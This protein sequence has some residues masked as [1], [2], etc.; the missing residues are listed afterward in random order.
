MTVGY[1][2]VG[3]NY[4]L[5][6]VRGTPLLIVMTFSVEQSAQTHVSAIYTDSPSRTLVQSLDPVKS[7]GN[8]II[9]LSMTGVETAAMTG[10]TY[11]FSHTID[12]VELMGG[13]VTMVPIGTPLAK[14]GSRQDVSVSASGVSVNISAVITAPSIGVATI[15]DIDTGT[16][17][18]L[19]ITPA[20]LAGSALQASVDAGAAGVEIAT[21]A[22]I[23]TG[24]DDTT[25]VSPAGLA[26]SALQATA[27]AAAVKYVTPGT[28]SGTTY[29]LV[30]ADVDKLK[31]FSNAAVVT[32]TIPTNAATALPVGWSTLLQS[33]G[34][35]GLTLTTTSLTLVGSL[36]KKTIAQ[37]ESMFLIKSATD[38]WSIIGG[39]AV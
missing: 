20:G 33:S 34:A 13:L 37:N 23:D 27:D 10:E 25:A 26:G 7:G 31:I 35:G 8:L 36:P 22:E 9:T 18:T 16:N 39:T 12:G 5:T 1:E 4:P 11:R 2:N 30:L 14:D 15:A 3:D 29:T 21:I 19:A 32:V 28:E 38:T 6:I 17:N 24:T